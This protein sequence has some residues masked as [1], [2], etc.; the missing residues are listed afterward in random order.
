MIAMAICSRRIMATSG[1]FQA[2][3]RTGWGL[4]SRADLLA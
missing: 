2:D 1:F 3:P 4:A